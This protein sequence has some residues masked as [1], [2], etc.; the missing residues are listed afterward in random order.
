M[1]V[2]TIDSHFGLKNDGQ[3]TK[4]RVFLNSELPFSVHIFSTIV[5][6]QLDNH[7]FSFLSKNL[8]S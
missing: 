7:Q 1:A 4:Q 5:A 2:E 8:L 6:S 3:L